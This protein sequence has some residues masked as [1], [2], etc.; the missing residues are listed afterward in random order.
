MPKIDPSTLLNG[1]L[2]KCWSP[3]I[4]PDTP[5]DLNGS[6][7]PGDIQFVARL[8]AGFS[9][10]EREVADLLYLL[11]DALPAAGL[12]AL[13][14]LIV[15]QIFEEE[16]HDR[17]FRLLLAHYGLGGDPV[18]VDEKTPEAEQNVLELLRL[19]MFALRSDRSPETISAAVAAYHL[20][21]EGVVGMTQFRVW[22]AISTVE[23]FH[24]LKPAVVGLRG[25][26]ARHVATGQLIIEEL[27]RRHGA[28]ITAQVRSTL[29]RFQP[30]IKRAIA[31]PFR[32]DL[33]ATRFGFSLGTLLTHA[34][35][36]HKLRLEA[37]PA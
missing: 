14:P 25:D 3:D 29:R 33:M 37:L 6:L 20:S 18:T 2:S 36:Q 5:T 13:R 9:A 17:L 26:E 27:H 31:D 30:S 16:R 35:G 15:A 11:L 4:F 19:H 1:A 34:E 32:A 8:A 24:P 22:D 10:G 28:A 7:E 12:E 21:V 23:P